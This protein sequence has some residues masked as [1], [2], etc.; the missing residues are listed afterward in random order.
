MPGKSF[1]IENVRSLIRKTC[2]PMPTI[3]HIWEDFEGDSIYVI[4]RQNGGLTLTTTD[5][6]KWEEKEIYNKFEEIEL[7]QKTREYLSEIELVKEARRLTV[8]NINTYLK[9]ITEQAKNDIRVKGEIRKL[10][11]M[12]LENLGIT[13]LDFM[14]TFDIPRFEKEFSYKA[15][16][17]IKV[18]ER[19]SEK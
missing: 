10:S 13:L 1:N 15:K 5:R 8:M 2:S 12:Q 16:E 14:A 7:T 11:H 4:Y 19:F 3:I 17:F 6:D 9:L 18:M